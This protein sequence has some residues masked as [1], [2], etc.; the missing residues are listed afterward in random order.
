MAHLVQRFGRAA[1]GG[2]RF[3]AIDNEPDLWSLTHRD[4]HP[5]DMSYDAMLTTFLEYA[6]AVKA[7]DPTA[8]VVGPVGSG[9]MAL[10]YSALDRGAR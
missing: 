1:D 9:W 6:S 5:A 3:Y 10:F 2:V 4:V 8:A 7:V